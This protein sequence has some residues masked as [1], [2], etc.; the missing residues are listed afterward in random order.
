MRCPR[1]GGSKVPPNIPICWRGL[2]G[3]FGSI[4]YLEKSKNMI[5]CR[6]ITYCGKADD[7]PYISNGKFDPILL[8][9]SE[10]SH[11]NENQLEMDHRVGA[12]ANCPV[13][14]PTCLASLYAL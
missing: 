4:S 1:W 12:G 8:I 11:Q 10:R 7:F 9:D 6:L 13:R 3:I 2:S 5:G 14:F